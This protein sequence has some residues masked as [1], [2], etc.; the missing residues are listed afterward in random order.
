MDASG[1]NLDLPSL[2]LVGRQAELEELERWLLQDHARLITLRDF[3]GAGKT[4]LALELADR[5][6]RSGSVKSGPLR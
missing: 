6:R 2:A 1:G 3:G 5:V 4:R